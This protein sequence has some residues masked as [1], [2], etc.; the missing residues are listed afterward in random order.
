[1]NQWL[2]F[3]QYNL[4]PN[5]ATVRFWLHSLKKTPEELGEKLTQK[6]AGGYDALKVL[7]RGL[8]GK[9]FLVADRFSLADVGLFAYTHVA[10]E[11]RFSL[12]EYPAIRS[13]IARVQAEP[14]H[15]PITEA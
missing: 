7:E 4:E 12:A 2:S 10:S 14:K 1:M 11:G 8:T 15:A 9:R 3:E 5:I 6:T 13:W